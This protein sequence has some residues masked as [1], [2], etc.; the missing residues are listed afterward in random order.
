MLAKNLTLAIAVIAGEGQLA[1]EKSTTVKY[2]TTQSERNL[3]PLRGQN[4]HME[5]LPSF[6]LLSLD[7]F[8]ETVSFQPSVM[9]NLDCS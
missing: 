2:C 5:H 4:V 3:L 1:G 6:F 7:V 8:V 9:T